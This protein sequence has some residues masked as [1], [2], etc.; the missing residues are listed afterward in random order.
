MNL[1]TGDN[2]IDIGSPGTAGDAATIR[3]GVPGLQNRTLI[4]GI[5][6]HPVRR[7]AEVI[8]NSSGELGVE[9]SSERYK[10]D[11]VSLDATPQKLQQ[12]R[13]VTFRLKTGPSGERRYGLIAEEVAQV[14][15]DLVVRDHSGTIEGVRYDELAPILLGEVQQQQQLIASQA[16]QLA[17]LQQQ[18]ADL[19]EMAASMRRSPPDLNDP[20]R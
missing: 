16:R 18:F 6:A 14:Y 15:P 4:A 17:D 19:R 20:T 7:G 2:N 1:T 3:I 8:I 5:W 12:L 10:T 13:P 11:I 9:V